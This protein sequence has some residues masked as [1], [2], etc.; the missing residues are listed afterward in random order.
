VKLPP[1][2]GLEL[3][4]TIPENARGAKDYIAR[5]ANGNELDIDKRTDNTV[6]VKI[7]PALSMPGTHAVQ[8]SKV[9]ADG[10][11]ERIPGSYYFSVQ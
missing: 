4:L 8:L 1:N 2:T 10:T 9:K 6:T 11:E 3:T 7:P 5:L